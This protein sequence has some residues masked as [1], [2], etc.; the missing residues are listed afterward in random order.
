MTV[1]GD[2]SVSTVSVGS[3]STPI[4]AANNSRKHAVITNMSDEVV[5][6]SEGAAAE[7]TKGIALAP[8]SS[9]APVPAGIYRTGENG[10]LFKGA[11]YGI[12]AS[13]SK[14]VAVKES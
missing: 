9:G 10:V 2:N 3:S 13:G 11:I 12:C 6:L 1:L 5:Y 7:S 8:A 4:L 14:S